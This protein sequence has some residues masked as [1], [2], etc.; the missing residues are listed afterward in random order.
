MGRILVH[1]FISLDG[2]IEKPTWTF[3]FPF[4]ERTGADIGGIIGSSEALLLGRQTYVEFAPAWS[5]RTPEQDPGAPFFNDSTKYVVSGSTTESVWNNTTF[6]GPYSA[7]TI[8]GL[9]ERAAK[10][11][12]VSGSGTLVRAL[13][14]DGLVDELHLFTFP[15]VLGTGKRLFPEGTPE[16]KLTLR[17]ADSYSS[18]VVH[19]MYTPAP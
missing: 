2:V 3:Q 19:L 8:R 4:D 11:L 9:K 13:L 16:L 5:S 1:E 12:Y 18:G 7:A 10:N 6:V 17:T 15:I 14:A